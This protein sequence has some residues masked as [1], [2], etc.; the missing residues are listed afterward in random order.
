MR[1]LLLVAVLVLTLVSTACEDDAGPG[2]S[3]PSTS[4]DV[5][6]S[7]ALVV[8]TEPPYAP[9]VEEEDGEYSG[10][11]IDLLRRMADRLDL[12]LEVRPTPYAALDDGSALRSDRCD[13]AA[14]ALAVTPERERVMR[15]LE[16][17]YE[18][19]LTLLRPAAS[20]IEGLADMSGRRL[21]VQSDS[22]A[23]EYAAQ[24]APSDADVVELPGD[25]FMFRALRQGRVDAVLQDLPLNL[26][27]T[28]NQR[29]TTVESHPTGEQ[30]AFAVARDDAKLQRSLDRALEALRRER[31]YQ[32]LYDQYFTRA[33]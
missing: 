24:Q 1:E 15:F 9:F 28:E 10:F 8:C 7:G 30:Y 32:E 29:F 3:E 2:G 11:E 12:S 31:V 21:A 23:S 13:V 5:V 26:V 17:H 27:H 19:T 33:Q 20:D 6:E 16:P 14:G 25:Q 22:D 4:P 18:V